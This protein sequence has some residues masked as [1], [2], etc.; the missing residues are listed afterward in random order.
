MR[1]LLSYLVLA[2]V[3]VV[4]AISTTGDRLLVILDDVADKANYSKFL[5]DLESQFHIPDHPCQSPIVA[6][7][8]VGTLLNRQ[9]IQDRIRDTKE[10]VAIPLP[11]GREGV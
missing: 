5:G 9:G 8:K 10:R 6:D 11:S 7:P 2:F 3:S 4:A 1:S